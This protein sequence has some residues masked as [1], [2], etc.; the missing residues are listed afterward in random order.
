V[1]RSTRGAMRFNSRSFL[2]PNILLRKRSII[3][4]SALKVQSSKFKVQGS[5][6][7]VQGSR[8]EARAASEDVNPFS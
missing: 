5:R 1:I 2:L 4:V 6:F 8:F 3:W 7:K